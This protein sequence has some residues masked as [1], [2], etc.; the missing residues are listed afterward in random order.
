MYYQEI[1]EEVGLSG[2]AGGAYNS[3]S[4][5]KVD[6]GAT[7]RMQVAVPSSYGGL[8]DLPSPSGRLSDRI[9]RLRQRC[10]EALGRDAFLD[11]YHFLKQHEEVILHYILTSICIIDTLYYIVNDYYCYLPVYN[12]CIKYINFIVF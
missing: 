5:H 8:Q 12:I 11:A 9:E 6:A 3:R 4:E 1:A 10:T 2:K 7:V